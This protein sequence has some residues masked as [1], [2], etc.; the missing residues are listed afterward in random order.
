MGIDCVEPC[1]TMKLLFAVIALLVCVAAAASSRSKLQRPASRVPQ[2][3]ALD[4]ERARDLRDE[5][6]R[7]AEHELREIERKKISE[8]LS[9]KIAVALDEAHSNAEEVEARRQVRRDGKE[10]FWNEMN[11]KRAARDVR[12]AERVAARE[13]RRAS[14]L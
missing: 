4:Q 11:E 10:A 14:R 5:L 7:K 12:K 9:A 8:D 3:Y 6:Y 1:C 13:E 2:E